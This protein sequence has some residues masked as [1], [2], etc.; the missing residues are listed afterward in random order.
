MRRNGEDDGGQ[1]LAAE[2]RNRIYDIAL[3]TRFVSVSE[4]AKSLGVVENTIRRDLDVLHTEGKL[5]RS[6]GGAVLKERGMPVPRYAETR[7]THLQEKSW[8]GRAAARH[9]PRSG[10]IYV[11]SGSTTYQ[12]ALRMPADGVA[13]VVTNSLEI[14]LLLSERGVGVHVLG[15]KVNSESSSTTPSDGESALDRFYWD[16]AFVGVEALD[17]ER[18]ITSSYIGREYE[19]GV[20]A[21]SRMRIALCDSSKFGRVTNSV[22]APISD[23]DLII[24]DTGLGSETVSRLK[25]AGVEVELA[26]PE[27]EDG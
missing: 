21:R 12:M 8:I 5:V 6:H 15:G 9:V 17:V 22:I 23:I 18:G 20:L 25:A 19:T 24:S 26:G 3:R 4:L 11:N 27:G 14:A 2:R 13:E 1:R 10:L 7:D 16:V